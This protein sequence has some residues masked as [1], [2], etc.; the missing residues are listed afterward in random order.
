MLSFRA[1]SS[2]WDYLIAL[3]TGLSL[4]F[5]FAP[6]GWYP[7][8]WI[9][10]AIFFW[11][12]L[13]PMQRGQ[14]IRLAWVFGIGLFAGGAHWIFYSIYYFGGANGFIATLMVALFVVGVALC[15]MLFGWVISYFSHQTN[16]VKLLVVFP[17]AWALTEWFR[18]WF[19]TP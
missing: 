5:A 12:N 13:K 16:L 18:S 9:A 3:V 4:V 15:L 14:R 19:L 1:S 8:A 11:L 2:P 6:F 7:I 10:T 17:A